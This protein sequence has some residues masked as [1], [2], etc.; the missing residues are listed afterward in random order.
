MMETLFFIICSGFFGYIY[1][2]L[3]KLEGKIDKLEEE[4]VVLRHAAPKRREDHTD[5]TLS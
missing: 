5:Y 1:Q 3:E 4:V 2:K